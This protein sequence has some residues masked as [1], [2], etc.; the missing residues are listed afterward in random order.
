MFSH[1]INESKHVQKIQHLGSLTIQQ[2]Q[3]SF[4]QRVMF[5]CAREQLEEIAL[6]SSCSTP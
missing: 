6:Q 4:S 2:K 5:L 3:M 1:G